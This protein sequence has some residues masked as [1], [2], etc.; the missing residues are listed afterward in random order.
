MM[1]SML[2]S[3]LKQSQ[4][5]KITNTHILSLFAIL[6]AIGA[7][8][9]VASYIWNYENKHWYLESME[10][11]S[12]NP[13]FTFLT[14]IILYN[15]LIPISLQVTLEVVRFLQ[16]HF[17]NSDLEMYDEDTDT[18]AMAR[19]SNLN[20]GKKSALAASH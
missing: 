3:P 10:D 16:A 15:N 18:P 2:Q 4:V 5:D 7:I 20:E 17:I 19:T 12:S 1:N 13:L 8:S 14:F 6:V 9:A 11:I